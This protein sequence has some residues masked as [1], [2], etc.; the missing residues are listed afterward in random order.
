MS[1]IE[2]PGLNGPSEALI[3]PKEITSATPAKAPNLRS[4]G[5]ELLMARTR[6]REGVSL[7]PNT[8]GGKMFC[9]I[10]I[11]KSVLDLIE[12]RKGFAVQILINRNTKRMRI[13]LAK[14]N[15]AGAW[16]PNISWKNNPDGTE[17]YT[18]GLIKFPFSVIGCPQVQRKYNV[19]EI[20][21]PLEN[22]VEFAIPDEIPL[23]PPY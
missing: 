10:N 15:D 16:V 18:N 11:S 14:R 19:L 21:M 6:T 2:V 12:W 17:G 23:T 3:P 5:F 13:A 7:T 22:C 9:S 1:R 8:F 20:D 4:G